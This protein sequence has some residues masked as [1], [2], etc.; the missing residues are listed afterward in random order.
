MVAAARW[1]KKHSTPI[2]VHELRK[3]HD[4]QIKVLLACSFISLLK[5]SDYIVQPELASVN[6]C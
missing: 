4:Y 3:N 5:I 6:L 1:I 2:L